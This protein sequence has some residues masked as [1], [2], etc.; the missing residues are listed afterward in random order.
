M[1]FTL[2]IAG[3]SRPAPPPI[4]PAQ[5]TTPNCV[6]I[7]P[8]VAAMP[9]IPTH[10]A[11]AATSTYF[12]QETD[13][14]LD[15]VY[16]IDPLDQSHTTAL[17]SAAVAAAMGK[18]TGTGNFQDLAAEGDTL[19]F[20]FAGQ[21]GHE[22]FSCVG[23][24]DPAGKIQILAD[25]QFL[26]TLCAVG[27]SISI[28]R[29]EMAASGDIIWL[30]LHS[31]D[32]SFFLQIDPSNPD[33]TAIV[34]RPFIQPQADL[35]TLQFTNDNY[36]VGAG[37]DGDLLVLDY[38]VGDLW[39]ISPQGLAKPLHSLTGLPSSASAPALD[40]SER[41]A[42][43]FSGTDLFVPRSDAQQMEQTPYTEFPALMLFSDQDTQSFSVTALRTPAEFPAAK[44]QF[45]CMRP[46]SD[47][48]G[49]IAYNPSDGEFFRLK[50]AH[51]D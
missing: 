49:W 15:T 51:Q 37:P 40:P 26:S 47:G 41:I 39:Q 29:A 8:V 43:F 27:D 14:G 11:I 1:I 50:L 18:P 17:T 38:F 22:F 10:L 23:R 30:W 33:A 34:S 46:T 44:L 16:R 21:Q 4:A 12:V 6:Q 45:A 3:C 31:V 36:A 2:L 5:D 20:Y 28:Y 9:N 13:N 48:S 24:F 35:T 32:G 42:I 25:Y 7:T 19:Y